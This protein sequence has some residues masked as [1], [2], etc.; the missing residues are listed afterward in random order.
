[1]TREASRRLIERRAPFVL[2]RR[3]PRV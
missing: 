3:S 2:S 1:L